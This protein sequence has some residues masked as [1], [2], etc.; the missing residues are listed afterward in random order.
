MAL[1]AI[2]NIKIIIILPYYSVMN[3]F[4]SKYFTSYYYQRTIYRNHAHYKTTRRNGCTASRR[5][6]CVCVAVGMLYLGGLSPACRPWNLSYIYAMFL[7]NSLFLV[8]CC[9]LGCQYYL[10]MAVSL[11]LIYYLGRPKK[12]VVCWFAAMYQTA[13]N[14]ILLQ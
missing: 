8:S 9:Q 11:I 13:K 12:I 10:F 2:I 7:V 4:C 5:Q 6:S 1:L 14:N 3:S